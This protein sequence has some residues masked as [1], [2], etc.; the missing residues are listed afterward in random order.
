MPKINVNLNE[1]EDVSKPIP[2][3]QY[4]VRVLKAEKATGNESGKDYIH[5]EVEVVEGENKGRHLFFNTSLQE[6]A[7]WNL[8]K[9][10]DAASVVTN[11]DGSFN[12]E[13]VI[14]AEFT[15]VVGQREYEGKAGN[16]V[17]DYL[18]A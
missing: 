5:W 11:K 3:G 9:L 17:S 12:T 7:L 6:Q 13:D 1:V 2:T 10:L 18:S 8:K 15:A 14:G 4:V 16:E